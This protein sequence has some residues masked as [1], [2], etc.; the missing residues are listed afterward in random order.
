MPYSGKTL[1]RA[2]LYPLHNAGKLQDWITSLMSRDIR[3]TEEQRAVLEA[4]VERVEIEATE[5]QSNTRERSEGEPLFGLVHG[6]PGTGKTELIFWIRELFEKQLGW[7]HGIQFVCLAVQN[8][9]AANINGFTIHHWS[10]IPVHTGV[11]LSGTSN[12]NKLST[13]RQSLRFLLVD[14]VSMVAAGLLGQLELEISHVTRQRNGYK[15]RND[16]SM[17]P[18]GGVNVLLFGDWWQIPRVAGQ[19]LFSNQDPELSLTH[20]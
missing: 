15:R 14:E 18:F 13:K 1:P 4:L 2:D 12:A 11:G 7:T 20:Y 9:M 6:F 16:G 10:G 19:S 17:R 3:P 8:I 5:E